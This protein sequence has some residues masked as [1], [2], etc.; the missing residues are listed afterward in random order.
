MAHVFVFP[1]ILLNAPPSCPCRIFCFPSSSGLP[2]LHQ[3]CFRPGTFMKRPV[4]FLGAT[5]GGVF[6][7]CLIGS[8]TQKTMKFTSAEI[9]EEKLNPEASTPKQAGRNTK[10]QKNLPKPNNKN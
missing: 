7:M 6:A 3:G 10:T 9:K 4:K 2:T 1:V 5:H 8:I